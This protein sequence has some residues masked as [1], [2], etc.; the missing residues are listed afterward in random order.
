[1]RESPP[2]IRLH[3]SGL[4]NI[5]AGWDREPAGATGRDLLETDFTSLIKKVRGKQRYDCL[6]MCSGGKDS[7]AALYMIVRR[8]R[9]NPLVFTFNHGFVP[10]EHVATVRRTVRALGV[11]WLTWESSEMHEMF[12]EIVR[13]RSG[14]VICPVCSLW[15]MSTTYEV[16]AR[17]DIPLIVSGW[18]KG[19][20]TSSTRSAMTACACKQDS[21]EHRSMA[22]ATAAFMRHVTRTL[23]AYR[24]FPE[25][26]EAVL[27]RARKKLKT[28]AMAVSPHWFLPTDS[29]EFI[30]TV[31]D[32]LGWSYPERSY[33]RRTTNCDLNFVSTWL[34]LRDYGYSHYHIELSNLVRRA[35][36]TR[37][38]AL[39]ALDEGVLDEALLGPIVAR[40]GLGLDDLRPR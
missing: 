23:P 12:R 19:Q 37:D 20:T 27:T 39:A 8:Y 5:C 11:D 38:E 26:M 24:D 1:M 25:N 2:D 10:D 7:T 31:K 4:C 32:E 29:A 13:S 3:A 14:T 22:A 30:E 9:L 18:T 34:A 6:V 16:A 35:M 28:R 15:Y 21:P 17:Y 36:I 40:L 33:P